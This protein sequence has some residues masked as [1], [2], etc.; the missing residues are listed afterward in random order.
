MAY[1]YYSNWYFITIGVVVAIS[2]G[3]VVFRYTRLRSARK[4]NIHA[5]HVAPQ[6]HIQYVPATNVIVQQP[7]GVAY[8]MPAQPNT[9][10]YGTPVY[11]DQATNGMY[12]SAPDCGNNNNGPVIRN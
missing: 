2:L 12:A 9:Q 11:T 5:Y 10:Q 4:A 3:L 6:P 1:Y 7:G 8:G